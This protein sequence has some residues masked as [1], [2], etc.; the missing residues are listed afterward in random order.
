V[1][2]GI[3][4]LQVLIVVL[5]ASFVAPGCYAQKVKVGYDK[6][7]DFSRYKSYTV[8]EPATPP[9]RPFLY[10]HLVGSIESELQAKGLASVP[11]DGDLLLI[12]TGGVDYGL[13][14]S[15]VNS[16]SC[17]NCKA[18]LLDP[19]DWPRNTAPPGVGGT[20]VPKGVVE[21]NFVDPRANKSVWTGWVEQKLN[22]DKKEQSI[23]RVAKAIEKLLA[24]FPPGKK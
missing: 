2:V 9:A 15:G 16:G 11:K 20:P 18:P 24:G 7:V 1:T 8:Q 6:S 10:A 22:A 21:L 23:E 5:A 4:N 19:K 3:R 17:A 14:S 13:D 12:L